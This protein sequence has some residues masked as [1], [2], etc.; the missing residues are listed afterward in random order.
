[1]DKNLSG[2]TLLVVEEKKQ[3]KQS[4]KAVT[5]K[6][7]KNGNPIT[8]LP[9]D[10]NNPDF[11]KIDKHANV[12]EN[13]FSNFIRQSKNP[14]RFTFF[15]VPTDGIERISI[16]IGD[17]LKNG[18]ESGKEL[19]DEYR[20]KPE[21]YLN[22]QKKDQSTEE[23]HTKQQEK[24]TKQASHQKDKKTAIAESEVDWDSLKKVGISKE[25][26]QQHKCLSTMLN[27]GKSPL[28]PVKMNLEGVKIDTEARLTFRKDQDGKVSL[29]VHGVRQQPELDK[30]FYGHK[31]TDNEK[32]A[33]IETG[34]LGK[35]LNM[36]KRDGSILPVYVSVDKLTN[37]IVALRADKIK[38]PDEIKGVKLED[39]QKQQLQEGKAVFVEGM[40]SKSGKEFSAHLQVNA[41]RRGLEFIFDKQQSQSQQKGQDIRIPIKLG[42]IELT[43]QQQDDLKGER[44]IY[45]KGLTD[46]K[47]Q[48][49][50]AYI[51][52]NTKKGK[53]DFFKWNPDKAQKK[54]PD[55]AHK[56]QE[57]V[58]SQG[59]TDEATKAVREPL[60]Q[61]QSQ[62]TEKQQTKKI[63]KQQKT[64]SIKI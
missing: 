20:V 4:I 45:V 36:K 6:L 5:G 56:I 39:K 16:V 42:G 25:I 35:I 52:V 18:Y 59:K 12:L 17:I 14:T 30:P 47:G 53:L 13:F 11:L 37:E 43:R 9:K 50:N 31:F 29:S 2:E 28:L 48:N 57:A 46:K 22:K 27:Y 24:E 7:D 34:N 3:G 63:E 21:D 54:T 41:S 8:V 33:L 55:N 23:Q 10:K 32:K 40:I 58:N 44:T 19:L 15:K 60:K 61:G 1:M 26:L 62:A 49:Y 64:R 51:K 38:T